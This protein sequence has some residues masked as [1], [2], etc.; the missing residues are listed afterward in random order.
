MDYFERI[1]YRGNEIPRDAV[2][3]DLFGLVARLVNRLAVLEPGFDFY[4]I[5]DLVFAP[6]PEHFPDVFLEY[7]LEDLTHEERSGVIRDEI[8][9][10]KRMIED[11]STC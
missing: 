3:R 4:P 1:T 9:T 10:S 6:F 2:V 7:N 11:Y 5:P 8:G